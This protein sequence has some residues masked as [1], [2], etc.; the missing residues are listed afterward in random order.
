[1]VKQDIIV[2]KLA[3]EK[4]QEMAKEEKKDKY[5]LK[6][7]VFPGGCSGLQYGMDF[8]KKASKDDLTFEQHGV[9]V[10]VEKDLMEYLKG[11]KIDFVETEQGSGFKIDNPNVDNS[12][13]SCST[14]CG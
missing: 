14:G 11:T 6:L 2:T 3:A 5:G 4:I 12:C 8:E 9:K 7:F 10:F 1:M 13:G